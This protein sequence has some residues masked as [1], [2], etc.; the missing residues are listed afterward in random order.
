MALVK[1]VHVV[2]GIYM[3]VLSVLFTHLCL[4]QTC[5]WEFF[6]TLWF[7]WQ[8]V[9]RRRP[10]RTSMLVRLLFAIKCPCSTS[11]LDQVYLASRLF[12]LGGVCA[13]LV[14]FNLTSQYNCQAWIGAVLVR[15]LPF[16]CQW[17]GGLQKVLRFCVTQRS[18]S[19]HYSSC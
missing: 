12:A 1:S 14:G 17:G 16:C 7:E 13:Q 5:R 9:T 3:C 11:N 8:V 2:D 6:T 4:L 10:W 19:T 18:F 15:S